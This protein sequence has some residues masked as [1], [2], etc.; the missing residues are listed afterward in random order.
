MPGMV[1]AAGHADGV[2]PIDQL[3]TEITRRVLQ[4]RNATLSPNNLA[5]AH[6]GAK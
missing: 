4:S 5:A 1:Y 2:Y 3:A 6:S